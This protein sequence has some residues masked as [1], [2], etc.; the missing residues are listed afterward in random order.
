LHF[1]D[2]QEY[3]RRYDTDYWQQLE[4][5]YGASYIIPE[6]GSNDTALT[7]VAILAN[8]IC[9]QLPNFDYLCVASGTAT[10]LRG[11]LP[12]SQI[13]HLLGFLALRNKAEVTARF[14]EQDNVTLL[15]QYHFGGFGKINVELAQFICQFEAQQTVA[16][17]PVYTAKMLYGI[18][19][20]IQQG[21][22]KKQSRILAIHSGGVQGMRGMKDKITS[23]IAHSQSRTYLGRQ[24]YA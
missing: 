19:D 18:D 14:S 8:A 5:C 15:E 11:L 12:V 21:Y 6:G 20:L 10:T 17:D 7:G 23:L 9:Q 13:M 1:A 3:A 2:K 22:F 4:R 16:L 24:A